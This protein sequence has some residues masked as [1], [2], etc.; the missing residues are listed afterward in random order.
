MFKLK[1]AEIFILRHSS[2]QAKKR[3]NSFNKPLNQYITKRKPHAS[4][5]KI[6]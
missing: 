1:N 4:I 5:Y 2:L 3:N 6:L